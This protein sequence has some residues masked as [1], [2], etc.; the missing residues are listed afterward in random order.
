[1]VDREGA[2]Y[3]KLSTAFLYRTKYESACTCKAHPW[4]EASLAKHRAYAELAER[5]SKGRDKSRQSVSRS[6]SQ[7]FSLK[8][9]TGRERTTKAPTPVPASVTVIPTAEE[10]RRIATQKSAQDRQRRNMLRAGLSRTPMP[11]RPRGRPGFQ[12]YELRTTTPFE[13]WLQ[14]RQTACSGIP[15]IGR[16]TL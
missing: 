5:K 7:S 10:L 8:E 13:R 16:T 15:V 4:E 1:M 6:S 3:K 9:R 12:L 11:P 14:H 2:A